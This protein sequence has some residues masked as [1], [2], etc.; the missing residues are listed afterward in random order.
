MRLLVVIGS[1]KFFPNFVLIHYVL[2]SKVEVLKGH[3]YYTIINNDKNDGSVVLFY[4]WSKGYVDLG[5]V[6]TVSRFNQ[7]AWLFKIEEELLR[8]NGILTLVNFNIC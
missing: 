1:S 2:G 4:Y 5:D 8:K 3:Y 6:I 7:K